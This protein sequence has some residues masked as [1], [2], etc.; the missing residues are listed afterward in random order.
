LIGVSFADAVRAFADPGV[1]SAIK[2]FRQ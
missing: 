1:I 2:M